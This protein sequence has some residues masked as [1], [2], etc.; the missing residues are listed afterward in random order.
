MTGRQ[1]RRIVLVAVAVFLFPLAATM[2]WAQ[3]DVA[4]HMAK[5]EVQYDTKWMSVSS[6]FTLYQASQKE[7]AGLL[8]KNK[9]SQDHITDLNKQVAQ[10]NTDYN[11]DK[12]AL[13][14]ERAK[15]MASGQA[16]MN[17]YNAPAPTKPQDPGN[18][19]PN[20]N[21]YQ[22]QAAY[23]QA[24]NSW[25]NYRNN[26]QQ[27]LKDYNTKKAKYDTDHAAAKDAVDAQTAALKDCDQR[28]ADRLK[29]RDDAIKLLKTDQQQTT[30]AIKAVTAQ[31]N[32][33]TGAVT[34]V[35]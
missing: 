1:V 24:N 11:K 19:S 12:K 28:I 16:A 21:Q 30:D 7:I 3:D 5:G 32:A 31:V 10:A 14:T 2:A 20:R 8:E 27:S 9:A 22:T 23:D 35:S 15:I 29:A 4:S 25:N 26:Y 18:N 33:L 17:Q 34:P 6:L 13:D